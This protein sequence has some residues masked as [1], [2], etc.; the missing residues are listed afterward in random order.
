MRI[1]CVPSRDRLLVCG[2]YLT[3]TVGVQDDDQD[4]Y[5]HAGT[6]VLIQL[7]DLRLY[8]KHSC[9][10]TDCSEVHSFYTVSDPALPVINFAKIDQE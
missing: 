8:V 10:G 4:T 3:R 5:A 9:F 6:A 2:Q 7:I 1:C